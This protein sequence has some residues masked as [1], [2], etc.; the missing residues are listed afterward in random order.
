HYLVNLYRQHGATDPR[1]SFRVLLVANDRTDDGGESRMI[2][3]MATAL[4]LPA[5][6]RDRL[7]VTTAGGVRAPHH[8]EQPLGVAIWR[9][10]PDERGSSPRAADQVLHAVFPLPAVKKPLTDA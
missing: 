5:S 4:E 3:L 6:V 1:P 10:G 9:R 2:D 8:H 7:W